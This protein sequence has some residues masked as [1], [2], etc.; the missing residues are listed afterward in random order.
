[1]P[2]ALL[3][4]VDVAINASCA[5][6]DGVDDSLIQNPAAGCSTRLA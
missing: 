6:V 1:M 3:P 4:T 5:N 2:A